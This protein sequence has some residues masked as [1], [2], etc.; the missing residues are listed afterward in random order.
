MG[1]YG[2]KY[3][4]RWLKLTVGE[5][6]R[7]IRH[8]KMLM[9]SY[10]DRC[11]SIEEVLDGSSKAINIKLVAA[12]QKELIDKKVAYEKCKFE[13]NILNHKMKLLSQL[14]YYSRRNEIENA[15][16]I[17]DQIINE[18]RIK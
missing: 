15:N 4:D 5:L 9:K 6:R 7:K 13:L 12:L 17:Y 11:R 3:S 14:K 18:G 16:L 1:K 2:T 10:E 8:L